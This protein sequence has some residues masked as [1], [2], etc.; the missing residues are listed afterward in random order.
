MK[1]GIEPAELELASQE[2]VDAGAAGP[3]ERH[4]AAFA[5]KGQS[6]RFHRQTGGDSASMASPV[7]RLHELDLAGM[8]E[9]VRRDPVDQPLI[10][11]PA[12]RR[13]AGQK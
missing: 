2:T 1:S 12:A 11:V 10:E 8:V 4:A 5:F 6:E 7:K 3:A 9:V 13:G